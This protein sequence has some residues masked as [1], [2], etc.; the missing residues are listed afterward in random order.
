MRVLQVTE[1]NMQR[2]REPH[3]VFIVEMGRDEKDVSLEL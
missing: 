1:V 2:S 3:T